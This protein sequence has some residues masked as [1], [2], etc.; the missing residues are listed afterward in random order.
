MEKHVDP[1]Q[2]LLKRERMMANTLTMAS[3]HKKCE[4]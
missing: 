2:I 1:R 3:A 4:S